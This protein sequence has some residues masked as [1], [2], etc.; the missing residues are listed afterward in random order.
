MAPNN[1]TAAGRTD[2]PPAGQ[3][4]L[5]ADQTLDTL[6]ITTAAARGCSFEQAIADIW[7]GSPAN[8]GIR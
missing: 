4:P 8:G 7:H 3:H 6:I 5:S 2:P 1:T